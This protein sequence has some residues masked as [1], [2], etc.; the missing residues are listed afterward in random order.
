M[1]RTPEDKALKMFRNKSP[2]KSPLPDL[3]EAGK[4]RAGVPE[5]VAEGY[6]MTCPKCGGYVGE[7]FCE[8]CG[9]VEGFC[10]NCVA[11]IYQRDL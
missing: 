4:G 6:N 10:V 2:F 3:Q 8:D 11:T 7:F 9:E 5:I 1:A